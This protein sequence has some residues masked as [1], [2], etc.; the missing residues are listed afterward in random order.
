VGTVGLSF[1]LRRQL[2]WLMRVTDYAQRTAWSVRASEQSRVEEGRI[3]RCVAHGGT[4][5]SSRISEKVVGWVVR[6]CARKAAIDK[7]LPM[8]LAVPAQGCVA[9]PVE[10]LKKSNFCSHIAR[11][12]RRKRILAPGSGSC[13]RSTTSWRRSRIPRRVWNCRKGDFAGAYMGEARVRFAFQ[14]GIE[15]SIIDICAALDPRVAGI[16]P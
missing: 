10:S 1:T 11:R 13:M 8:T 4:A 15:G 2:G 3:F 12:R 6:Q 5:W 14:T 9:Q 16:Q 7:A